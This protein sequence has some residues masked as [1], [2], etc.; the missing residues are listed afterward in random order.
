MVL[1]WIVDICLVP[2]KELGLSLK[3]VLY[4]AMPSD[5]SVGMQKGSFWHTRFLEC[6]W[7]L[8]V[9]SMYRLS[10][11]HVSVASL[12][13]ESP[14]LNSSWSQNSYGFIYAL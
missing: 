13:R 4:D 9:G 7:K 6:V 14:N 1:S 5:A 3:C 2:D 12:A 8:E 10:L 11:T